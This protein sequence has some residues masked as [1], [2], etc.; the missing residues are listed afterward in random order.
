MDSATFLWTLAATFVAG[1]QVFLSK[2]IAHERRD[3]AFN[4]LMMYGVSGLIAFAILFFHPWPHVWLLAGLFALADGAL[5]AIGNYIRIK[6][7]HHIDSVIYFP[8]NKVLGPLLVVIAGVA[9]FGDSLSLT[10]YIGIFFSLMVPI[11]L[12]SA[13]EHHRQNNLPAGLTM[14]VQSTVLTSVSILLGKQA[15]LYTSDVLFVVGIAQIAGTAIS[16]S[17]LLSQRGIRAIVS[18]VDKRDVFLGL[19]SGAI[20][21]VAVFTLFKAL[22]TGLVSLV[23][24]IQAHYILIP[25]ILSVW[26]YK[27]HINVRKVIA[28]LVSSIAIIL[29]YK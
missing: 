1:I 11:L 16:G 24:V 6:S 2:V 15:L 19:V 26:W 4:G 23:Y 5:H 7:L 12:L 10:Q 21:F 28:I 9:W 13:V 25:I 20:G 18:H 27:E 29:L 14:L 17:I 3:A 22:S 8:I